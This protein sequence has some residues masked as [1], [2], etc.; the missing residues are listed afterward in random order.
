MISSQLTAVGRV[1]FLLLETLFENI[2]ENCLSLTRSKFQHKPN[3]VLPILAEIKH[4]L[5]LLNTLFY[6]T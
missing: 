5:V 2:P 6:Y 4:R 1:V 3:K